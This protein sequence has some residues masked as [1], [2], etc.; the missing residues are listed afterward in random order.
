MA[1]AK[2]TNGSIGKGRGKYIA[3]DVTPTE[4][5]RLVVVFGSFSGGTKLKP[6]KKWRAKYGRVSS[7]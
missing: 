2:L 6:S 4:L 1:E 7:D 5:D 3:F